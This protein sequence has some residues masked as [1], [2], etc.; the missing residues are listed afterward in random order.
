MLC[1]TAVTPA[2]RVRNVQPSSQLQTDAPP[3]AAVTLLD[4]V[5]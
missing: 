4:L 2:A 1:H 3:S 5:A